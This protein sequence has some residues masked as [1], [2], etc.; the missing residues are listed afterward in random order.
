ME[1][2]GVIMKIRKSTIL[3]I[4]FTFGIMRL[5]SQDIN[6]PDP[7]V[8]P[9]A[10]NSTSF[11][12]ASYDNSSNSMV[13]TATNLFVCGQKTTTYKPGPAVQSEI[14]QGVILIDSFGPVT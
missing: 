5:F 4:L 3:S 6:V 7:T 14:F 1:G 9:V 2:K 10:E 8:M 11:T 13:I 12:I